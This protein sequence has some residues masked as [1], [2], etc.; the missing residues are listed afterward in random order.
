MK[1]RRTPVKAIE[2]EN[3]PHPMK[4]YLVM[5]KSGVETKITAC[6]YTENAEDG[7]VYFHKAKD[8]SDKKTFFLTS[9]VL[10]IVEMDNHLTLPEIR[11]RKRNAKK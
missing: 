4:T 6:D 5:T 11:V 2:S 1:A 10:A 8:K 9:W 3:T 7:R